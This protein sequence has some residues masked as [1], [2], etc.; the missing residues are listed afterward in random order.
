[1]NRNASS[2]RPVAVAIG[3]AFALAAAA[4][5]A[6]NTLEEVVVTAQRLG[7]Q[8]EAEQALTPGGV[9]VIDGEGLYERSVSNLTDLLRYVPGVWSQSGWGS[10]ELFFSSR[11]SNLDA[12]DYDKNGVKLFQDGLPITTADGN[13]HNRV[14]DPL[15]ARYAVVARGANALTYG[16]STLGGAFDFLSPT[17]RTTEPLSIYATGGSDGLVS[18]RVTAGRIADDFDGLVALESKTYDGYRDHSAQDRQGLYANGGWQ[19]SDAVTMRLYATYI[20]ND[21]EL[22]RGLT[23]E[24][25]A[26]DPDQAAPSAITG[27][28]RKDVQTARLAFT[29]AWQIDPSSTLQFGLS[30]EDQSLYHPIV[31]VRGADPDGPGPELGPQFFSL[32]IDTDHTNLGGMIR[33]NTKRGAHDLLLGLNYGDTDVK[34]GYY[35]NLFGERNGL[36]QNVEERADGYE[37]FVVDRWQL[38]DTWT[39]VYGA[40]AVD[41]S[42]DVHEIDPNGDTIRHPRGDYS[43]L[44]PRLGAIYS[45]SATNELFASVSKLFEAPTTFELEDDVRANNE[46]LE[47]MEGTVL[48]VGVRGETAPDAGT[49][50]H[51][52]VAVYYA[53]IDDEILS[54]EDPDAPGTSLSSNVDGTI[55]AGLEALI[56]ATFAVG[57][58]NVHRLEPLVSLALNDFSFDGDSTYGDNDLPAAPTYAVRGEVIYR[59]RSGFHVGPTFDLI[60]KRYV[61][62]A[63]T[64]EVDA[65]ELLGLRGG[66]AT[67]GWE[68]F[69]ELRN[70]TDEDYIATFSVLN[71]ATGDD[72]IYM[73]GAPSSAYVGARWSF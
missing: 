57:N 72:D 37:A 65:Y 26:E 25:I 1:M 50:W 19:I 55:H 28:N 5:H 53:K 42:R 23:L 68:I 64:T 3:T 20:D 16:A 40:Q 69:A 2:A 10:D 51:W 30:Y 18:G 32:L 41:T 39:L 67:A 8:I 6:Q 60:G 38:S 63:N 54:V 31:D 29:A 61:D 36:M 46:L 9:T 62:S 11:G 4:G 49:R 24:Q 73:P 56:G 66:F 35:G 70:L 14:L 47:P 7:E 71:Q 21:E 43:S 12:T 17:A 22:P 33:Y 27:D 58:G 45:L 52:D 34:G 13:N 48:E 15:G 44:N 59:H